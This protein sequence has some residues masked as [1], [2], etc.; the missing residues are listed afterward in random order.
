[1]GPGANLSYNPHC[2]RRDFAPITLKNNSGSASVEAAM[3]LDNYG[4]FEY[5]TEF[6][7][8]PGG[9]WGIGGLYG[10]MSDKWASGGFSPSIQSP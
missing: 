2:I 4:W 9:H 7:I 8:H 1:M 6:S 5:T 3:G 10:T